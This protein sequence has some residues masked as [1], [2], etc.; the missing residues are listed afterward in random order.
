MNDDDF[1]KNAFRSMLGAYFVL[2]IISLVILS[3]A[4]WI[5]FWCLRH[6]GVLP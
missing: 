4:L 3:G 2:G 5:I 1:F 6:F